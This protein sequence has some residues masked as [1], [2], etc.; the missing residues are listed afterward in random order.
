MY[1]QLDVHFEEFS[2]CLLTSSS[3][4]CQLVYFFVL[5]TEGG[6]KISIG[7]F[8]FYLPVYNEV[9][10]TFSTG[11]SDLGYLTCT[12]TPRP[13]E[14]LKP[15][16]QCSLSLISEHIRCACQLTLIHTAWRAFLKILAFIYMI[17]LHAITHKFIFF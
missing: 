13:Y 1:S 11:P 2:S 10:E 14:I 15:F 9:G 16:F 5:F 6:R 4:F 17:E 8:S 12:R 7:G 3:I